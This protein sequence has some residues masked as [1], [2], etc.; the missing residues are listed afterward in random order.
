MIRPLKEAVE[1]KQSLLGLGDIVIPGLFVAILHRF[2][3]VVWM[4]SLTGSAVASFNKS[5]Q[6]PS[7]VFPR[8]YF[9]VAII[10]YALGLGATLWGM[11][12]CQE[13]YPKGNCAQPALLYL[14]PAC[15]FASFIVALVRSQ[16]L[17]LWNYSEEE[18]VKAE[19]KK[20][21]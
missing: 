7:S 10:C 14:V 3:A 15:M 20:K 17:K 13:W 9:Y 8:P 12:K 18:P 16:V 6:S 5:L 1:G 2:D 19:D 11:Q 4:E 21:D